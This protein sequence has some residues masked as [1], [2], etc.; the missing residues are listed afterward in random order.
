[1][2][3][4]VVVTSWSHRCLTKKHLLY[5]KF[6]GEFSQLSQ[7]ERD[8]LGGVPAWDEPMPQWRQW[9]RHMREGLD[10]LVGEES[11]FRLSSRDN[12]A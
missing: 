11:L 6:V 2:R 3:Q 1:M 8:V 12:Y 9:A 5:A 7:Y 10:A 4:K